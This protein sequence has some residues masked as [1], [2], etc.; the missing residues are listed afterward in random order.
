M[1]LSKKKIAKLKKKNN[2]KF[3]CSNGLFGWDEME[4]RKMREKEK[5]KRC[6][7]LGMK[8]IRENSEVQKFFYLGLPILYFP[9]LGRRQ[10][11]K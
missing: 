11:R 4:E 9:K 2:C 7:W 8:M 6:V 10:E 3:L 1:H 5:G